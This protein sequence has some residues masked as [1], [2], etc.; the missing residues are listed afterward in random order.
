MFMQTEPTIL[1]STAYL[2]PVEY[3]ALLLKYGNAI[4]EKEETYPKQTYRNRCSILTA[5]GILN[6]SI[7]VSKPNG[8]N[9]KTKD[10]SIINSST[11]YTN[12]WRAMSSAYSGSPF[13][14]YYKDYLQKFFIGKY[15]NLLEYN[16]ELMKVLISLVGIDCEITYSNSFV[17]PNSITNDARYSV[18]PKKKTY[19]NSYN[20][21]IQV[22][23]N[24]FDFIPNLSIIDLLFNLGPEAKD[25][26]NNMSKQLET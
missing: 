11:W 5:N 26:L 12:H 8:N 22:F 24:K 23:S 17:K 7:P 19:I 13:F 2:P 21:Y 20:K 1:L 16:T 9:T 25:Y 3:M 6:L 10:I 14:L 15:D 4:I 18:T